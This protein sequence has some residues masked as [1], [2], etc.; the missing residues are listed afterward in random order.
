M[1][2]KDFILD[3]TDRILITGSNGFIGSRVVETLLKYGYTNLR[4]L[5][6]PSS[7]LA[8]LERIISSYKNATVDV[9]KGNLQSR[10]DCYRIAEG[11]SVIYHLAAGRGEK[12][13]PDAYMNSVVTTRNLLDAVMKYRDNKR[14]VNISSLQCIQIGTSGVEA[15]LMN[16]VRSKTNR[17]LQVRLTVM[18]KSGRKNWLLIMERNMISRT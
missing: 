1:K 15:C 8:A 11:V 3:Y 2:E 10:D 18:P 13:Y 14:F 9:V 6:R 4:C 17:I 5:V 7:N 16:H 12:S